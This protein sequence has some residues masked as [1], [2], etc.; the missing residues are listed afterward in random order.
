M[1]RASSW[2]TFQRTGKSL[3]I[4]ASNTAAVHVRNNVVVAPK[5]RSPSRKACLA[6]GFA[7]TQSCQSSV[8]I[9]R[10]IAKKTFTVVLATRFVVARSATGCINWVLVEPLVMRNEASDP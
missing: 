9:C 8:T 5:H 6:Q 7:L 10:C 1:R 2:N 3:N 4:I